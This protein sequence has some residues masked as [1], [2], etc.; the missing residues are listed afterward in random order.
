[1]V[2][3]F[4]REWELQNF[5]VV[6]RAWRKFGSC[7]SV[8]WLD[9]IY[10]WYWQNPKTPL[11]VSYSRALYILCW[12]LF[13]F[14]SLTLSL[15][16]SI[17]SSFLNCCYDGLLEFISGSRW[18]L[19]NA[20]IAGYSTRDLLPRFVRQCARAGTRPL[21]ICHPLHWNHSENPHWSSP[22]WLF[23]DVH[24]RLIFGVRRAQLEFIALFVPRL[25]DSDLFVLKIS[26]QLDILSTKYDQFSLSEFLDCKSKELRGA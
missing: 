12:I 19:G 7:F 8:I 5:I 9:K 23:F 6:K 22:N 17:V 20:Q 14:L 25:R 24:Y 2:R 3:I 1:M 18:Q 11:Y 13:V 26:F 16:H 15:T 21:F 10:V 4:V